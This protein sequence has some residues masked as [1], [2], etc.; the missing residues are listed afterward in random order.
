[1]RSTVVPARAPAWRGVSVGVAVC[2]RAVRMG[3]AGRLDG[4]GVGETGFSV[5]VRGEQL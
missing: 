3:G 1:M 5:D 4:V 2:R